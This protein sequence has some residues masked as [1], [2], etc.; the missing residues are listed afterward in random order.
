[1]TRAATH[2]QGKIKD[3]KDRAKDRVREAVKS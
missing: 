2:A 3:A 1:M